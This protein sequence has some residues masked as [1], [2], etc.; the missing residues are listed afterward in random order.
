LHIGWIGRSLEDA[1]TVSEK[2]PVGPNGR[3]GLAGRDWPEL[4]VTPRWAS[5]PEGTLHKAGGTVG[6]GMKALVTGAAGFIGS[7]VAARLVSDGHEVVGLDDLSEEPLDNLEDSPSVAFI[8]ADL[9]DADAVSNAAQGCEVIFHQG[10]KRSVP[11][12]LAEPVL[13]TEVNVIGTLNVLLAARDSG[14][15]VV[16]ASSASIYGDQESFP[17]HEQMVPRP[18]S[19]YAASKL[20][21]EAYAAAFWS[22]LRVPTVSL[23]YFNVYGP[24][25]DPTS[26]YAA[27]VPRFITACLTGVR[28]AIQ[29][30]GD[31]A[32]DFTFIDDVVEANLKGASAPESAFGHAFNVGGGT[33]PTSINELL[34]LIAGLT[35]ARP[36]PIRQPARDGDIR[37]TAADMSRTER[38]LGHRPSTDMREGLRRTVEWFRDRMVMTR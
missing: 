33:A 29:G 12:S 32:R 4:A 31:Q 17:L 26:E 36:D 16:W 28:P 22:S 7:R 19:P 27:V 37:Y 24:W 35:G 9:R 14:A 25:Q 15:R 3:I 6:S 2:G 5:T 23:R 21:G 18:K 13:T 34:S 1:C 20:A 30:D 38:I 8:E 10:A 11:R